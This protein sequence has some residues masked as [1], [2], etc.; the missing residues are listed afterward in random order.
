M[1]CFNLITYLLFFILA[2]S[3]FLKQNSKVGSL[4]EYFDSI[5]VFVVFEVEI[6]YIKFIWMSAT[7]NVL[8]LLCRELDGTEEIVHNYE[9]N[10]LHSS[11]IQQQ[12]R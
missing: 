4:I 11:K 7:I 12:I 5:L 2:F 3:M 1:I 9:I 8:L 10:Q 6:F